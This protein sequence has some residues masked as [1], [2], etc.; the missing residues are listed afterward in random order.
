MLEK[1]KREAV[2]LQK[3]INTQQSDQI[4]DAIFNFAVTAH[5]IKDWAKKYFGLNKGW[6]KDFINQHLE[7]CLCADICNNAKH[8]ELDDPDREKNDPLVSINPSMLTADMT[9]FTFDQTIPLNANTV[10]IHL[11]SGKKLEIMDFT[12]RVIALWEKFLSEKEMKK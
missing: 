7:L 6:E 8:Q 10:R 5:H 1:A 12:N 9:T 4:T 3:A 11:Q 2:N